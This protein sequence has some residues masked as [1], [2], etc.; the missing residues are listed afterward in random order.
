MLIAVKLYPSSTGIPAKLILRVYLSVITI[1]VFSQSLFSQEKVIHGSISNQFTL[2]KIPFASVVWK[3][4]GRG[5]LTD[6]LGNFRISYNNPKKD[7]LLV[8]YVGY[9]N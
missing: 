3:N 7:T 8:T 6:S 4:S 2:E 9:K 1:F 5:T